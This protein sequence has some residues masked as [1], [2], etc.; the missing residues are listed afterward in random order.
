MKTEPSTPSA[1]GKE[2]DVLTT[3][4]LERIERDLRNIKPPRD[5]YIRIRYDF[6]EKLPEIISIIRT[7]QVKL[8]A[9]EA[10]N[11]K[12]G[13]ALAMANSMILSG[14]DHSE[15]SEKIFREA[16]SFPLTTL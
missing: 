7:L 14:E 5:G 1:L 12:M 9:S 3:I 4:V 8:E 2:N 11:T 10:Q 13:R 6:A 15:T 16:L